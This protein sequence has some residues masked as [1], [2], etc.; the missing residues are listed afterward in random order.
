[1][2]QEQ[3]QEQ[4]QGQEQVTEDNDKQIAKPK[5]ELFTLLKH[6]VFNT[7]LFLIQIKSDKTKGA[8]GSFIYVC[9]YQQMSG[10]TT[11]DFFESELAELVQGEKLNKVGGLVAPISRDSHDESPANAV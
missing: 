8:R 11:D 10:L 9:R 5:F 6:K 1:M 2:E 4:E 3:K 7:K